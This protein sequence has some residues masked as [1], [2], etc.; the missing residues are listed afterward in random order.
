MIWILIPVY[1]LVLVFVFREMTR[2]RK[3]FR[4]TVEGNR[5][6]SMFDELSGRRAVLDAILAHREC[7]DE[8][9]KATVNRLVE[10][11]VADAERA[12]AAHE[13]GKAKQ[14]WAPTSS[15][16]S[17]HPASPPTRTQATSIRMR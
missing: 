13:A 1:A 9:T 6:S 8:A 15:I 3:L 11:L 2:S 5:I 17:A 10:Q 14:P 16:T 4:H 7:F 12:C